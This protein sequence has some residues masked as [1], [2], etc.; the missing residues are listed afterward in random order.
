MLD[1]EL[2]AKEVGGPVVVRLPGNST[3]DVH[4]ILNA[5]FPCN[6]TVKAWVYYK[7][8]TDASVFL[9]VWRRP[10]L[11]PETENYFQLIGKNRIP[12]GS[13]GKR[14]FRVKPKYRIQVQA[15]DFIGYHY[16][17]HHKAGAIAVVNNTNLADA[18]TNCLNK[19]LGLHDDTFFHDTLTAGLYDEN[20]LLNTPINF[21]TNDRKIIQQRNAVAALLEYNIESKFLVHVI[22]LRL[23][24]QFCSFLYT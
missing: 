3:R 17:I 11:E 23:C 15:G 6:G 16:S 5:T 24:R 12:V 22:F 10:L 20:F 14:I 7:T 21:N 8:D 2:C 9:S 4:L 19:Y 1:K 13:R 18:N